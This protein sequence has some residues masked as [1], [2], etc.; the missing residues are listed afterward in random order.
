MCAVLTVALFY[1]WRFQVMHP[2]GWVECKAG[3]RRN[4]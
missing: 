4:L 2:G 3:Q 1:E